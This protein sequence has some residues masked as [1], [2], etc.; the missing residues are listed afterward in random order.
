MCAPIERQDS[1]P[2]RAGV[3]RTECV[4]SDGLDTALLNEM[5]RRIVESVH[6]QQITLSARPHGARWGRIATWMSWW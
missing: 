2:W 6:P 1:P 4:E 3:E 5:V